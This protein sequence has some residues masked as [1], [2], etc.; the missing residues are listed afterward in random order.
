MAPSIS[1]AAGK[2]PVV[3]EEEAS[4]TVADVQLSAKKLKVH[5]KKVAAGR[6]T[7]APT[8]PSP[9]QVTAATGTCSANAK[10][11]KKRKEQDE[12]IASLER[13]LANLR[14]EVALNRKRVAAFEL[15]IKRAFVTR[16][17]VLC[18]FDIEPH[19]NHEKS[20]Q[21]L[22]ANWINQVVILL[23]DPPVAELKTLM[24][25]RLITQSDLSCREWP[26]A[27]V[28]ALEELESQEELQTAG[29]KLLM[30]LAA[31]HRG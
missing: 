28:E 6:K 26:A 23:R 20:L 21:G 3:D 25:V 18:A 10:V 12:T 22:A 31:L 5:F 19:E 4:V 15:M 29:G 2:K 7:A 30:I 13:T 16:L 1:K 17:Y 9:S 11:A 8:P 24:L 14:A 27:A